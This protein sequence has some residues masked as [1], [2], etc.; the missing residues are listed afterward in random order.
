MRTIGSNILIDYN[1]D[2]VYKT[3]SGIHLPKSEGSLYLSEPNWGV[4]AADSKYPF[5][6][7]GEKVWFHHHV[8]DQKTFI[9]GVQYFL[10]KFDQIKAYGEVGNIKPLHG[11]VLAKQKVEPPKKI[12]EIYIEAS[13]VVVAQ[14]AEV[15]SSSVDEIK[16]KDIIT[17]R[18]NADYEI[19]FDTETYYFIDSRNI[20]T[21]NNEL[22]PNRVEISPLDEA[23]E[24]EENE[25]GVYVQRK[26]KVLKKEGVVKR[27]S[28]EHITKGMRV[29]YMKNSGEKCNSFYYPKEDNVLSTV[30]L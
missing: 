25:Q 23:D 14:T 15:I 18:K 9:D 28:V 4:V 27:S 6:K 26:E 11:I 3:K 13:D 29:L 24:W 30:S 21:V 10:A 2:D 7:K 16:E 5:L 17:Y 1:Y 19:L 22:Y 8:T 12:G 20:F